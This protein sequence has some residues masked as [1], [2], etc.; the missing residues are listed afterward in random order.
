VLADTGVLDDAVDVV[1]TGADHGIERAVEQDYQRALSIAEAMRPDV[2]LVHSMNDQPL[3]PQHGAPLRLIVPG[4]YGM[5]HVKWLVGITV[6]AEPFTG[7]QNCAAYRV[8]QDADDPGEPVTR[9]LP[10]AMV[11]PPGFPDF[12]TR[13]RVVE[14]GVHELRGRAWSGSAPIT[15]VEMSDDGGATWSDAT[16]E[17]PLDR[18]AWSAWRWSWSATQPG[19]RMLCVRATDASGATQPVEQRWNR[20]AMANNH[21]QHVAVFVR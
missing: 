17:P 1:F 14:R 20:Q 4:W 18:Y 13:T 5:A 3:P 2:L 11:I 9:I 7:Y 16:V 12:Q 6:L 15:R 21:V 10:R 19:R 8:T